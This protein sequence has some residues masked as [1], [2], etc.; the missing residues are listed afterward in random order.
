MLYVIMIIII[1]VVSW[2]AITITPKPDLRGYAGRYEYTYEPV[3]FKICDVTITSTDSVRTSITI[4]CVLYRLH[5]MQT[6]VVP[7]W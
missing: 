5:Q 7:S 6:Y 2:Y 1:I 3:L 4:P